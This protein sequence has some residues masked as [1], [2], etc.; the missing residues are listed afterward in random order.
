[1]T[2]IIFFSNISLSLTE[3][4]NI[5]ASSCLSFFAQK[6]E[7]TPNTH[8]YFVYSKKMK[9]VNDIPVRVCAY[10]CLIKNWYSFNELFPGN[11]NLYTHNILE[12]KNWYK[13]SV[14]INELNL[15]I[16]C[17]KTNFF[18]L[19]REIVQN[20]GQKDYSHHR[21]H[22]DGVDEYNELLPPP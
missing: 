15:L 3:A 17:E 18:A 4:K 22:N 9:K 12:R 20:V 7:N 6:I 16:Y 14:S 11:L 1:M 5:N 21:T 19:I 10:M 2:H 8:R 13:H